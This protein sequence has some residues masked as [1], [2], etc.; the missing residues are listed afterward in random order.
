MSGEAGCFFRD[1]KRRIGES[2]QTLLKITLPQENLVLI[3]PQIRN[4]IVYWVKSVVTSISPVF[5][6][7]CLDFVLAYEEFDNE[8]ASKE[9]LRYRRRYMK[10]LQKSQLEFE[11]V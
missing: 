10:N 9:T 2:V 4:F 8:P 3:L 7:P 1:Q 11:E 5:F 6:A